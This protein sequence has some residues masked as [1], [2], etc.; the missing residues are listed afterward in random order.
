MQDGME[1]TVTRIVHLKLMNMD[2]TTVTPL[3]VRKYVRRTG[4]ART[5]VCTAKGRMT[6]KGIT[7][8]TQTLAL[9]NA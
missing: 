8:A 3:P 5:V 6:P 9:K 2:T 4:M 1:K 7:V